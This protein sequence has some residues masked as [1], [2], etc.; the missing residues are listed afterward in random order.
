MGFFGFIGRLFGARNDRALVALNNEANGLRRSVRELTELLK[1]H[2][3]NQNDLLQR[4]RQEQEERAK[5]QQYVLE[6]ERKVGKK[7]AEKPKKEDESPVLEA[8]REGGEMP[9]AEAEIIEFISRNRL[10]TTKDLVGVLDMRRE[11]VSRK[12][13]AMVAK[14]AL[15]RNGVGKSTYYTIIRKKPE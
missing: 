5:L 2:Q 6:L 4:L 1:M 3:K 7:P 9:D 8:I 12:L 11:T 10:A 15:K 13:N 14:R